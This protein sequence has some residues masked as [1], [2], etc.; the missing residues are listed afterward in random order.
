MD[1]EYEFLEKC[2]D[3][4]IDECSEVDHVKFYNLVRKLMYIYNNNKE[5][6]SK[7]IDAIQHYIK[8][9]PHN[10]Q[11]KKTKT[12]RDYFL[13]TTEVMPYFKNSIL[14]KDY[15]IEDMC[16]SISIC[17]YNNTYVFIGNLCDITCP[18]LYTI[19]QRFKG[20]T[21]KEVI[22]LN[23]KGIDKLNIY[24]YVPE[25]RNYVLLNNINSVEHKMRPMYTYK[26]KD[27]DN[28]LIFMSMLGLLFIIVLSCYLWKKYS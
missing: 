26:L 20:F 25:L 8:S 24:T 6:Y 27:E 21:K 5:V 17:L 4:S 9:L 7:Y 15:N 3:T 10:T 22:Y 12:I 14:P 19:G 1:K 18:V 11:E 16:G 28:N 13:V 2:V 23:S